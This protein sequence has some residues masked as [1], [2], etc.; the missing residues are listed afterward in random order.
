MSSQVWVAFAPPHL[1]HHHVI[2]KEIANGQECIF[3]KH[4]ICSC[5]FC[6]LN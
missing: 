4:V 3:R 6:I 2:L 5:I 1:K